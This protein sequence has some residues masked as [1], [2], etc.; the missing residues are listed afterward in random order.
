MISMLFAM[1]LDVKLVLPYEKGREWPQKFA[2]IK[3]TSTCVDRSTREKQLD[4]FSLIYVTN[5]D[6]H[7]IARDNS[8]MPRV[9][10]RIVSAC[11]ITWTCDQLIV[12]GLKLHKIK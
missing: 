6:F 1:Q 2:R 9:A 4:S 12:K 3:Q 10:S 8:E 7:E 11:W 5:V